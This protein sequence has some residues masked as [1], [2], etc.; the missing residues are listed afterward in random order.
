[1]NREL[2]CAARCHCTLDPRGCIGEPKE[3]ADGKVER[4]HVDGWKSVV[5]RPA[6]SSRLIFGF[7]F[8]PHS[9]VEAL[10][11]KTIHT[12]TFIPTFSPTHLFV[13][14]H[15]VSSSSSVAILGIRQFY[16]FFRLQN[17]G[18]SVHRK[19]LEIVRLWLLF[20]DVCVKYLWS[21]TEQ[22]F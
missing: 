4:V 10:P 5:W 15:R 18:E 12:R 14:E 9:P 11:R 19:F 16:R 22:N 8:I 6:K 3:S 20:H 2:S 21:S 1:M 17:L 13:E 7:V